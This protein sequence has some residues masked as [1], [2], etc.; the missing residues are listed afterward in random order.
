MSNYYAPCFYRID[1]VVIP[2]YIEIPCYKAISYMTAYFSKSESETSEALK[3]AV[4]ERR[5]QH[6]KTKD[7]MRKLSHV[8]IHF[9][10]KCFPWE[11]FINSS[12]PND[13][14]RILKPETELD[15]LNDDS[16]D[17]FKSGIIEKYCQ[18][19]S[20]SNNTF[21]PFCLATF[22]AWYTTKKF[23]QNDYQPSQLPDNVSFEMPSRLPEKIYTHSAPRKITKKTT[24]RLVLR[25]YLPYKILSPDK[26]AYSLLILFFPFSSESLL[27]KD[28]CLTGCKNQMF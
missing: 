23:D 27:L 3:Q 8:F 21:K 13:E 14:I 5:N 1:F 12:L 24:F 18:R 25:Y 26:Y 11:T 4:N 17:I 9:A 19:V 28:G 20:G 22:V 7:A 15:E 10:R 16:T 2:S 6:L